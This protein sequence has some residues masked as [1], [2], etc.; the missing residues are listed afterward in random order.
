M[1]LD[2]QFGMMQ[3]L[4]KVVFRA[5]RYDLMV[6]EIHANV[7]LDLLGALELGLLAS[8]PLKSFSFFSTNLEYH[9]PGRAYGCLITASMSRPLLNMKFKCH[10]IAWI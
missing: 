8:N 6:K 1:P 9:S 3:V 10:L 5:R 4:R 2:L 7:D